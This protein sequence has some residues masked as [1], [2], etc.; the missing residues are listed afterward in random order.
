MLAKTVMVLRLLRLLCS[1]VVTEPERRAAN[2]INTHKKSQEA[3]N[4]GWL[5]CC[6]QLT[7]CQACDV[8]AADG[9]LQSC[10]TMA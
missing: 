8:S 6:K 1:L 10:I 4:K 9:L 3:R 2:S 7:V 5:M